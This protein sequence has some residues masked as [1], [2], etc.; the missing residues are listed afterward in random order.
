MD[1]LVVGCEFI[2]DTANADL[3]TKMVGSGR[4]T[5]MAVVRLLIMADLVDVDLILKQV[6]KVWFR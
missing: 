4:T 5:L 1:L 2:R 3:R 6:E